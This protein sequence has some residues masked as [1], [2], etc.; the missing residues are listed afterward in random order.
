MKCK[1]IDGIH[2]PGCMGCAVYGHRLGC[3]CSDGKTRGEDSDASIEARLS[4]LE[5]IVADA[6]VLRSSHEDEKR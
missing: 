6:A 2:L 3:T 1:T 5:R 4:R